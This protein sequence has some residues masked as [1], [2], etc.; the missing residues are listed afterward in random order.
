MS[1]SPVPSPDEVRREV[2]KIL[3]S[4]S[5]AASDRHRRFLQFIVEETLQGRA[6][7][8]TESVVAATVFGRQASLDSRADSVVRVEARNLRARLHEY[9]LSEGA[10]DPLAIELPEGSYVPVFHAAP[11]PESAGAHHWRYAPALMIA[12]LLAAGPAGWLIVKH[13]QA[14]SKLAPSIAVLPFLNLAGGAESEYVSDGFVKDLTTALARLPGLRVAAPASAFQFRGKS[15]DVRRIGQAL[16]VNTVLEGSMRHEGLK[17]IVTA[18][19]INVE[20][21]LR[22]WSQSFEKELPALRE[23]QAEIV[24]AVAAS[25]ALRGPAQV[26]QRHDPPREALDA[27]WHGR[28]EQAVRADPKFAE[29]WAALAYTHALM[30]VQMEAPIEQEAAKAREAARRAM[31]LDDTIAETHNTL[32]I[33]SYSYDHDFPAA[34][35]EFL[36]ALQLNPSDAGAHRGYALA[37]TSQGRA[38]DA[39]AQ[40]ERMRQ[41][42]PLSETGGNDLATA[43]YYARRFGESLE[44]AQRQLET[45]PKWFPA[46]L[47]IGSCH[48]VTGHYEEAIEDLE[49]VAASQETLPVLGRLGYAQARARR[50]KD[51][52]A[53]LANI[54][55]LGRT[56]KGTGV[57]LAMVYVALGSNA[58]AI[59]SLQQAYA[60]RVVD[61][62]FIAVEPIFEPLRSEP[63][64]QALCTRLGL[65]VL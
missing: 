44:T 60:D 30:A 53:T 7:E 34:E 14:A 25:L 51:V 50:M 26:G 21:G 61:V 56:E 38:D 12:L 40:L 41:L 18:Q 63:A 4:A 22:V 28:Y 54:D 43:L 16:G 35:K 29:A 10:G 59:E 52:S 23:A 57:A 8:L 62:N 45:D 49:K 33:L 36:R 47:T 39:I 6:G 3:G 20:T 13:R 5:F 1:V 9:Y 15:E 2:D 46:W 58:K 48:E 65:P 17:L 31:E 19:L 32:A 11:K 24:R 55:K 64:F 27:Y 42:D 37:L